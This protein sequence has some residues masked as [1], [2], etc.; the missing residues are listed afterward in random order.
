MDCN[1]SV[2]DWLINW[3]YGA[4][5]KLIRMRWMFQV[6]WFESINQWVINRSTFAR[7][8]W[9]LMNYW[10]LLAQRVNYQFNS[11]QKSTCWTCVR[12]H[13]VQWMQWTSNL[14][15]NS[16]TFKSKRSEIVQSK[17]AI[18]KSM[19]FEWMERVDC[20]FKQTNGDGIEEDGFT[21]AA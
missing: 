12:W 19:G 4:D 11:S 15:L 21:L 2:I 14:Q 13:V 6:C 1:H 16:S 17:C 10:W 8:N 7:V 9:N 5:C 20:H 3:N 18:T